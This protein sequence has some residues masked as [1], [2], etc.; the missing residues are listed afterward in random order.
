[1]E[2]IHRPSDS[3]VEHTEFNTMADHH[4]P[5]R[6]NSIFAFLYQKTLEPMLSGIC[7]WKTSHGSTLS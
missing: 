2:D 6:R 7:L 5:I 1:M 3:V 4:K